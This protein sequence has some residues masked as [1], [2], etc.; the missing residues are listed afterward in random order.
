MWLRRL[1][2]CLT[3]VLL[4]G[5]VWSPVWAARGTQAAPKL[6]NLFFN[7]QIAEDD[8]AK[9][10]KWDIV[11]LDMDQQARF[12]SKLREIKRLNPN[13]K[14]LA[15][16]SASEI[17]TIRG[18]DPVSFPGRRLVDAI[19][20]AWYLHRANGERIMW[21]PGNYIL[22]ATDLGPQSSGERWQT[23]IG[24]FIRDQILS[25]GL[26]DGVFLDSAYAEITPFA[27][28]DVDLDGDRVIRPAKQ[29]DEAYQ[30][31]MRNLIQNVRR[32]IG[33]NYLIMNNSSAAYASISNGTLFE[34]FPR[35]G[36]AWPFTEFR[37]ALEQNPAPKLS[38]VNTNTNNQNNPY[39]YR[40]MRYGLTSALIAD[41]YFS[42]DAGD[43]G[44][45][46][47]WWYDEYDVSIGVP[48]AAAKVVKGPQ[49]GA[50]PAVWSREYS[51]GTVLVNSTNKAETIS[52]AGEHERLTGTQDRTTNSGQILTSVTVPPQDGIVLLRRKEAQNIREAS[53]TNGTFFQIY[54]VDGTRTQNGFFANRD[55]VAGGAGVSVVD[56][57]RDGVQDVITAQNGVVSIRFGTGKTVTSRPFGTGYKGSISF[58]VGQT[59]R[60]AKWEIVALP[61]QGIAATVAVIDTR[62]VVIRQWLAYRREFTGGASVAIGDVDGDG[63][64]EIVTA[65]GP[66]GGPHIRIFRTDGQLWGG[67]FFAF[68][69][70]DTTGAR[71]A[72]GDVDGDGQDE[73]VV[74]SGPG[75]IP[76]IQVYTRGRVL[77]SSFTLGATRSVTG[78]FPVLA[79]LEG[80]GKAEL[81]IPSSAF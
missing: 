31:G 34:N 74:G 39:D 55:D 66:G 69:P 36:W 47:T 40:L 2:G 15:Y 10:A 37:R 24:P 59:N 49:R 25:T 68:E 32:T 33:S 57:D 51:A 78:I 35:D 26:W 4:T 18:N 73:I 19:P 61:S 12:P 27:G 43:A 29:N 80:D 16:V 30:A 45:D 54:T 13:I 67:G 6:L 1:A 81:L 70:S 8:P 5:M 21:W 44:H 71:V 60:D 56:M 65:P 23:F 28:T 17:A 42:F 79:D 11:V 3:L 20:E 46:R 9:L 38:A 58:A 77:R 75:A 50:Y 48:R 72:V 7:W 63:L 64:N 22:N 52:L 41:G 14:L 62:G 53:F 76:R